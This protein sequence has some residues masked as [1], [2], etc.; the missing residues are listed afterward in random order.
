[1][2]RALGGWG[3]G[4]RLSKAGGA[5]ERFWPR[6]AEEQAQDPSRLSGPEWAGE[7]LGAFPPSSDSGGSFPIRLSSSHCPPL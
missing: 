7:T 2:G 4:I 6:R 5:Q 1:M 3:V